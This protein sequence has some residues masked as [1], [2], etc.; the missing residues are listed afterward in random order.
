MSPRSNTLVGVRRR[1]ESQDEPRYVPGDR[2]EYMGKTIFDLIIETGDIGIVTRVADGWVF[3]YWSRAGEA[4][5][6]PKL[7]AHRG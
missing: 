6:L 2:V 7:L 4:G 3:A 1:R 5:V